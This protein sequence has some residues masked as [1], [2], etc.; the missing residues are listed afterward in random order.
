MAHV[1]F[2][3]FL[4]GATA[5]ALALLVCVVDNGSTT[6]DALSILL[7]LVARQDFH[8]HLIIALVAPVVL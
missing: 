4:D 6:A 3:K 2:S 8:V 7:L 5:I 1:R